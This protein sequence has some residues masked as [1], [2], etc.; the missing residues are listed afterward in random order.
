MKKILTL[1][2]SI[3]S[4]IS[5]AQEITEKIDFG[6]WHTINY[7]ND[8]LEFV[9]SETYTKKK[10]VEV[11]SKNP[12]NGFLEGDYFD[13]MNNFKYD[14]LSRATSIGKV[15]IDVTSEYR[16]KINRIYSHLHENYFRS[17][18]CCH[19]YDE[20]LIHNL[21]L[22]DGVYNGIGYIVAYR[23]NML[24]YSNGA[25][26]DKLSNYGRY[27]IQK[28][29]SLGT[30]DHKGVKS[31][32]YKHNIHLKLDPLRCDTIGSFELKD[33]YYVNSAHLQ[34]DSTIL[35]FK[36]NMGQLTEFKET[37]NKLEISS[38]T[39]GEK[40]YKYKGEIFR[41][42]TI[43][44][45]N[46]SFKIYAEKLLD[47]NGKLELVKKFAYY[48]HIDFNFFG[49]NLKISNIPFAGYGGKKALRLVYYSDSAVYSTAMPLDWKGSTQK[50][51]FDDST[52]L[53][54]IPT[55]YLISNP[56]KADINIISSPN[57]SYNLFLNPRGMISTLDICLQL[58]INHLNARKDIP[59]HL[60]GKN[61]FPRWAKKNKRKL[62]NRFNLRQGIRYTLSYYSDSWIRKKITD[63]FNTG[64]LISS[65]K[66][67]SNNLI[68]NDMSNSSKIK[69]TPEDFFYVPDTLYLSI[70]EDIKG[71]M[72]IISYSSILKIIE[73]ERLAEQLET[74]R[75]EA[76]RLEAKRLE[77]ERL[78]A[79][80]LEI[81]R[82]D[83]DRERKE[84]KRVKNI[85]SK[86]QNTF[87]IDE[88]F[89][90]IMENEKIDLDWKLADI[91]DI[92]TVFSDY[93]RVTSLI[94]Y[95]T[96]KKQYETKKSGKG[97]QVRKIKTIMFFH[98][99]PFQR[100]LFIS[101]NE[102]INK[103]DLKSWGGK[104]DEAF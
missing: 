53:S 92:K 43:D 25:L 26:E 83:A 51:H 27:L 73:A 9:K 49:G 90:M 91:Y 14:S 45:K 94:V 75:L 68:F 20:I 62:F 59:K 97:K 18:Y 102:I 63:A 32:F 23:F 57:N 65:K 8:K 60:L 89:K 50:K 36:F 95:N 74:E 93:G 104:I 28:S 71:N 99:F 41:S 44:K 77:A 13:G 100:V 66:S 22:T 21:S 52:I 40:L 1:F 101:T 2:L 24:D 33:G 29:Y 35:S 17:K 78:E 76:E 3:S 103:K 87:L 39:V 30:A 48:P 86:Y 34:L 69:I 85:L 98:N 5:F 84:Q 79:E 61:Y 82:L 15:T 80:R 16:N 54:A 58:N 11:I 56:P 70:A 96:K 42:P 47:N 38:F 4:L 19:H 6:H 67:I 88:I 37:Y 55:Y 81:E 31:P 12:Y 10:L 64:T 72:T 46:H 7:L